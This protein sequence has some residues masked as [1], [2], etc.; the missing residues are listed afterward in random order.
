[1]K[2]QNSY[3]NHV[4]CYTDGGCRG[5]PGPGAI[6]V[7]ICDASN[8]QLD[9]YSECIGHTTNNRAE[10]AAVIKGLNCCAK[11]TRRRV[12]IFCDSQLVFR[13]RNKLNKLNRFLAA[14]AI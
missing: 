1:M 4:K 7:L 8:N 12:T 10:Y 2:I 5:N 6:G 3:V 11:F 14:L 13:L 9:T